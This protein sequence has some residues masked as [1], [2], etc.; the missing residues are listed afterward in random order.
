MVCRTSNATKRGTSQ[1]KALNAT[2][3]SLQLASTQGA[4]SELVSLR[5]KIG[6]LEALLK[7]KDKELERA[8]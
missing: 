2:I 1:I 3:Q 8:K 6:H 4:D 7:S 5:S